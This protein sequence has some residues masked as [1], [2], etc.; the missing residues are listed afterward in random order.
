MQIQKSRIEMKR[1]KILNVKL[2][3]PFRI[4]F[5]YSQ[6]R[7][8]VSV[9]TCLLCSLNMTNQLETEYTAEFIRQLLFCLYVSQLALDP[10]D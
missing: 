8:S 7:V 6:Q 9:L 2:C 5:M 3:C 10:K 4:V 1:P